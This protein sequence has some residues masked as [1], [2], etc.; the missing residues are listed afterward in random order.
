M[1][2]MGVNEIRETYLSF[3]EGKNHLRL[4]SFPL[5]PINDKSLLLINSGMAPMKPYFTGQETPPS[6][7]VT[8]CQKCIRT[9]DIEN[10]GI[11]ARHATLFEMLGN[12]SFGDYFKEEIIPWSWE[13]LTQ[14]LGIPED[15]LTV[16]V[17]EEDDEAYQIWHQKMGLPESKICRMGKD[18]N[19]WEV[20]LGPCGPCSEIYFDRGAAYGC[21]SPDC[22]PECDCGR[23]MEIWNLVFTQFSKEEDGSYSR[24][25]HPNIDTGAGL[26]RIASVMQGVDTIFDVDTLKSIRDRVCQISGV[27]YHT[28]DLKDIS[29]RIIT[30]HIRAVTF[31]TADGVLPSNEGRGYVLRRL[32]RRAARHGKLLGIQ[33][34]FLANLCDTVIENSKDAYPELLEKSDYIHKLILVEENRFYETLDQGMELVKN[35]IQR[36]KESAQRILSGQD[37][38][39][40][41]DTFGFPL[42]LLKE[43]LSEETLSIDEEAFA[44]EMEN[45]REMARSSR[46]ESTYMGAED[47]VFN[48]LGT[49]VPPTVFEGYHQTSLA[50][51]KVAALVSGGKSV[52]Q[53]AAGQEVAVI[54][55]RTPFYAESGGQ[56]G[57]K[58]ILTA[59]DA[60]VEIHDCVK[61]TGGRFAHLGRVL[62]GSVRVGAAVNAEVDRDERLSTAR[63]HTATHLLQKALREVLGSHV[64]QAGSRVSDDRLRFDFTHFAPL[65]QEEWET[66]ERIVNEHIWECLPVD[67][68]IEDIEDARKK[69]AMALFGEKYGKEVRLVNIQDYSLE[70]CGGTHVTNTSVI[71][72]FVIVSEGGVAAGVRRIEALTGRGAMAHF[73]AQEA[74]LRQASALLKAAPDMLLARI[75]HQSEELRGLKASLDK[76]QAA[77]AKDIAADILAKAEEVKG[78][79]LATAL[80]EGMDMNALRSLGDQLKDKIGSG[81]LMLIS[82]K[83]GQ[84]N[85]IVMA[86][87]D[88]VKAGLNAGALVKETAAMIGGGGGGRPNM[89][90]AGGKLPEK[91]QEALAAGLNKMKELLGKR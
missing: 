11:T 32:L 49:D 30:D 24:L 85:L 29:I 40:L 83:D 60:L 1:K 9:G 43:M 47:T 48:H 79:K 13:F 8:T 75:K 4:K 66:V 39:K 57:D 21:G 74:L 14:A 67:V 26:E 44:K 80:V 19:F 58:G 25:A 7:R 71:G 86:T 53:A 77:S 37:A 52:T 54:L 59:E 88:A 91:A 68:S 46:E 31:M 5:V 72:A 3:F 69:G 89:A 20:G 23:Y 33:E 17:Y 2:P 76:A 78:F 41:Y 6:K 45:Q 18:D 84:A 63:N 65:T 42:D 70:L 87:D 90:Q 28:S 35:H 15:R 73:K 62:Q 16:S 81:A 61:V 56:T 27:T 64:E 51:A 34:T 82:R 38:F 50:G 22:G 36:L 12:F 10:V 55:D